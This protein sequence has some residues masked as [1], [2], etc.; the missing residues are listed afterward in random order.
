[1]FQ[2]WLKDFLRKS[3]FKHLLKDVLSMFQ[4][5]FRDM[6]RAFHGYFNG[7]SVSS[8][9]CGNFKGPSNMFQRCLFQRE[10]KVF[11]GIYGVFQE[12]FKS[13]SRVFQG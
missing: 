10:Y 9:F 3:K 13:V 2:Q 5:S 7:V 12:N 8:V 11:Y 1:M 6:F 4:T